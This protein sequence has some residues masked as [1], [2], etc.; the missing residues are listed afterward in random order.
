MSFFDIC[1]EISA[2]FIHQETEA[3]DALITEI[4]AHVPRSASFLEK[5]RNEGLLLMSQLFEFD[6][7]RLAGLKGIGSDSA[8]KLERVYMNFFDLSDDMFQIQQKN[9]QLDLRDKISEIS[10]ISLSA[11]ARKC[12][13]Q[14]GLVFLKE[15]LVINAEDL[16]NMKNLG[17]K[18]R[19]EI[20]DFIDNAV[21]NEIKSSEVF[22]L[23]EC[24]QENRL[25]PI[26]LLGKAGLPEHTVGLLIQN[27]FRT[28]GDLYDRGLTLREYV[29]TK[30]ITAF[31][32]V[33]LAQH[34]EETVNSL[35]DSAKICIMRRIRG[36]SLEK[37]GKELSLTRERIRQILTKIYNGL[38]GLAEI[39]AC[40]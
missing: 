21:E 7:S 2:E 40:I 39:A 9:K 10:E 17:T 18:T 14:L 15:L 4:Y 24:S 29:L 26:A 32:S 31:L 28:A 19:T 8:E 12:L 20:L 38:S 36:A 35:K 6:F 5:C 22:Y 16:M 37:I 27:G 13:D 34:F 30:K 3:A 11:R 25:I 1:S 33:P 23:G